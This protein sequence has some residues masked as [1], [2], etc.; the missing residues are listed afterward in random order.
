MAQRIR[1]KD[2]A[3]KSGVSVGTVDRILHNRPNVSKTAREKVERVLKE[4]NYQPNMYASALAYNRSYT[5]Y[6]IM[7]KHE[8]EAYWEE[9]EE[10]AM[11][12]CDVRRDFHVDVIIKHYKRFDAKTFADTFQDVIDSHPN[13]VVVVPSD[14]ETTK[15]YTDILHQQNIPFILLDS[16]IPELKP[17]SFF[18]QDSFSSGYFAAKMLMLLAYNEKE[19][20]LMKQMKNG[21]LASKQQENREVGFRH[22]MKE[23]FPAVKIVE[24]DLPLDEEKSQY[25]AILEKFFS[26]HPDAHHCFTICSKAHIVGEFLQKTHRHNIQIMGYDMVGKNADCLKAGSISFLIAQHAYMQGYNS[27]DTLFKAIVLKKEVQPINYMPI[28]L[29]SKENVDFYRRYEK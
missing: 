25:E 6:L 21:K 28:E 18:G 4:I 15:K 12:A 8:S 13:G 23:H 22:Y 27:I 17:L 7:P 9:I 10:G 1:I 19:N 2:I 3:E 29:L 14:F 20:M 11:Q 16:Y 24:T 5:F 26:T